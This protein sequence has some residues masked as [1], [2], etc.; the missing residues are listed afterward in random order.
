MFSILT[1]NHIFYYYCFSY[2]EVFKKNYNYFFLEDIL[3][4]IHIRDA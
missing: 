3:K 1:E 2:F 4:T